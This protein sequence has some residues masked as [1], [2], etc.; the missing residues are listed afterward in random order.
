MKAQG[1][2]LTKEESEAFRDELEDI[3]LDSAQLKAVAGGG[4]LRN[5]TNLYR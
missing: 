2:G 3:G 5:T 1:V 4:H